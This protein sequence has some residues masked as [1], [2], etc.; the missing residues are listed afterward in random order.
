MYILIHTTDLMHPMWKEMQ[1]AK[2]LFLF[3]LDF[4]LFCFVC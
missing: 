2:F 4:N 1:T 3:S